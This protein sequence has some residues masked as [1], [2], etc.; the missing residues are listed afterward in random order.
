M[1]LAKESHQGF[2][3]SVAGLFAVNFHYPIVVVFTARSS[4]LPSL[5]LHDSRDTVNETLTS[6]LLQPMT[7]HVKTMALHLAP[8]LLSRY[9]LLYFTS[10]S[11][12]PTSGMSCACKVTRKTSTVVATFV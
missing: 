12:C 9:V 4:S 5:L 3:I 8:L 2:E 6:T 10:P 1:K 7:Q 11:T